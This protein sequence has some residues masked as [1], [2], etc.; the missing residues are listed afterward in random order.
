M[1]SMQLCLASLIIAHFLT[2]DFKVNLSYILVEQRILPMLHL[3]SVCMSIWKKDR[4][5][6]TKGKVSNQ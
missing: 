2:Q 6:M 3:S 5:S 1:D 4:N